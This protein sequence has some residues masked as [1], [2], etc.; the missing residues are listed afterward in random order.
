ME[1]QIRWSSLWLVKS[2][3]L[4]WLLQGEVFFWTEV[5]ED[6]LY[7]VHWKD[8]WL[9]KEDLSDAHNLLQIY[10]QAH[11]IG[12]TVNWTNIDSKDFYLLGVWVILD[13]A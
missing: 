2:E 3:L 6:K 13:F 12:V 5:I 9:T 4:V 11:N 8:S 7:W 1:Y 10:K